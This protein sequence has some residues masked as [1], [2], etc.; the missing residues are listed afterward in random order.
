VS[1]LD[2]FIFGS[3][4]WF[5]V[6]LLCL[7]MI[8]LSVGSGVTSQLLTLILY[9]GTSFSWPVGALLLSECIVA[10]AIREFRLFDISLFLLQDDILDF[11]FLMFGSEN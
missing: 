11:A 6:F 9:F 7:S 1:E 4:D 5:L 10:P 8:G 2:F 3:N